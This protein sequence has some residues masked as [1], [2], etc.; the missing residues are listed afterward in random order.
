MKQF[1]NDSDFAE[2][3]F[4]LCATFDKVPS[5][6]QIL[7]HILRH[8]Q[9]HSSDSVEFVMCE[10]KLQVFGIS[11]NS[12]YFPSALGS[13]LSTIKIA[14][15]TSGPKAVPRI[16]EKTT[17]WIITFLRAKEEIDEDVAKVLEVTV[18][19]NLKLLQQRDNSSVRRS[20][21]DA[22]SALMNKLRKDDR[23]TDVD[24]LQSLTGYG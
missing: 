19:R 22:I 16:A 14:Q 8:L 3:A 9:D 21:P 4:D 10:A 18:R 20:S 17:L 24:I 23:D 6:K 15:S 2:A 5:S 11:P 13:S 7:R 1:S 12:E